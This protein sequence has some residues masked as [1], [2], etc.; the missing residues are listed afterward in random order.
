MD[1]NRGLRIDLHIHS[2][3]SDGTLT[4]A[5]IV[6]EAATQGLA[7]ISITDHDTLE[8]SRQA[9]ALCAGA[10]RFLPGVEISAA[11]PPGAPCAGS[12]HILGYGIE[13]DEPVLND[14]LSLLQNARRNRNPAIIERLAALGFDI[15]MEEV[16]ALAGDAQIGRPHIARTMVHKGF[17][18][19]IDEAF[20]RYLSHGQPAYVDKYRVSCARALQVI[21][22]AGG[23]PVL[24]HP[25][26]LNIRRRSAMERLIDSLVPMGLAGIEV[27]YPE[28]P[29]DETAFYRKLAERFGLLMT[30]GTDFHGTLTPEIRLGNG[31]GDFCVPYQLYQRLVARLEES[32][33]PDALEITGS[34]HLDDLQPLFENLKYDFRDP[35]LIA[36][37]LC[38]SSFVNEHPGAPIHDNER[39]EFLGDAVLNL[40]VGH[41]L[42]QRYPHLREGELSRIRANLVN[43]TRLA[44]VARKLGLGPHIRLGRGERQTGGRD[45]NSI[46]ADT[47][48]AVVAA[49]YLDGGFDVAFRVVDHHMGGLL[50][51]EAAADTHLDYKSRLQE[52]VQL[53]HRETP[54][55]R[56]IYEEGPDHAKTFG[57][58][59]HIRDL[60]TEGSGRSKKLAEQDAAKKA[61]EI[62]QK[63]TPG[64]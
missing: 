33:F 10:I 61:L 28:H 8:G 60:K 63:S 11:P 19:N 44:E 6:Q 23:V 48:E 54:S 50:D 64:P 30:G 21:R 43:E 62:L 45:K 36:E 29:P 47:L 52:L 7:A 39:F 57:V 42:M 46:L 32:H 22:D 16:L 14:T 20:D 31:Q 59:L 34:D 40:I 38:H 27:Y 26:L 17:V 4:P 24:A 15:S 37:A 3:A 56:V 58:E 41:R 35:D 49:V 53:H 9:H 51:A 1:C 5:E 12:F 13:L 18:E 2:T 25:F 55:Y